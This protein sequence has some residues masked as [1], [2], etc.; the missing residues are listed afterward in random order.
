MVIFHNLIKIIIELTF[1]LKNN[2]LWIFLFFLVTIDFYIGICLSKRCNLMQVFLSYKRESQ[3]VVQRIYTEIKQW[4]YDAWI[5]IHCIPKGIENNTI[6]WMDHIDKALIESHVII[7]CITPEALKSQNVRQE[8]VWGLLAKRRM[9]FLRL[10]PFKDEDM[11][12]QFTGV[13]YVD[14]FNRFDEGIEEL[15]A[16][17]AG[18]ASSVHFQEPLPDLTWPSTT[19]I[20]EDLDELKKL[21]PKSTDHLLKKPDENSFSQFRDR[22]R[23]YW[24]EGALRPGLEDVKTLGI[25]I[26]LNLQASTK[27]R[28]STDLIKNSLD[29]STIYKIFRSFVILGAPGSGKTTILMHLALELLKDNKI[30]EKKTPCLLNMSSWEPSKTLEQWIIEEGAKTYHTS[31][32]L[33]E[34]WLNDRRFILLLDGFDE[35]SSDYLSE[36]INTVNSFHCNNPSQELVITTRTSEFETASENMVH[37][38]DLHGAIEL[39][40]IS[41]VQID[42]F[43]NNEDLK[44]LRKLYEENTAIQEMVRT[45]FLLNCLG[46][47]YANWPY[48]ALNP[49]LK[50]IAERHEHLFNFYLEKRLNPLPAKY[51]TA[52]V[53]EWLGWLANKIGYYGTIFR[54]NDV[55]L[56]WFDDQPLFRGAVQVGVR[57]FTPYG[58]FSEQ[59]T[60]R[61]L[62]LKNQP[63]WIKDFLE[64][65]CSRQI[66][67]QMAGGYTFRHE[68]LRANFL[69]ISSVTKAQIEVLV[70]DL[71][72]QSRCE[73]AS[74]ALIRYDDLAIDPLLNKLMDKNAHSPNNIN[75][76]LSDIGRK[77]T[78]ILKSKVN[79]FISSKKPLNKEEIEGEPIKDI[80]LSDKSATLRREE[81]LNGRIAIMM[82]LGFIG[83]PRVIGAF[84]DILNDENES[85]EI[86]EKAVLCLK[87]MNIPEIDKILKDINYKE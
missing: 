50:T 66:L 75:Q 24:L 19:R 72:I 53:K 35:I 70:N 3:T 32:A 42:A 14:F 6:T 29:I 41:N 73:A 49:E 67:R 56:K 54:P 38:F 13:N 69:R 7:A 4:N 26:S 77:A 8:W 52:K 61:L 57:G 40:V 20:L 37:V 82:V 43:M 11:P 18:C 87:I 86:R 78:N 5:D 47:A 33:I 17:L 81:I 71:F 74:E 31:P 45:P 1:T 60:S 16:I 58:L 30:K 79:T 10:E 84:V 44:G 36:C 25:P 15:K 39:G 27:N 63:L 83:H 34:R 85:Q 64:F 80:E 62:L 68:L 55:N 48:E 21:A 76:K 9:I 2:Y 59:I 28:T 12:H 65:A 23:R 22:V 46:Y 51:T